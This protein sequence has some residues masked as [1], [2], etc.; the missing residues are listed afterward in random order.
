MGGYSY[1]WKYRRGANNVADALSR[2]PL[3]IL[4]EANHAL[5]SLVLCPANLRQ[6]R[7]TPARDLST[8]DSPA[9]A[10]IKAAYTR[11]PDFKV[12]AETHRYELKDGLYPPYFPP[13]F[14]RF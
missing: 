4:E 5:L 3:E 11:N 10:E 2:Q 12:Q 13:F 6:R 7:V 8:A 9:V 14:P 1:T